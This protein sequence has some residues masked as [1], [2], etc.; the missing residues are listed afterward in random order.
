MELLRFYHGASLSERSRE[1]IV[2]AVEVGPLSN[3]D[4]E[5]G[6]GPTC[7]HPIGCRRVAVISVCVMATLRQ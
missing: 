4:G 1:C 3:A 6:Q 7:N 5:T 2:P